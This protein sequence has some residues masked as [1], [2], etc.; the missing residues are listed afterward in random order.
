MSKDSPITACDCNVFFPRQNACMTHL[1]SFVNEQQEP[2]TRHRI[3]LPRVVIEESMAICLYRPSLGGLS[4]SLLSA[5]L[6]QGTWPT[7]DRIERETCGFCGDGIRQQSRTRCPGSLVAVTR[8]LDPW[9]FCKLCTGRT[10][11]W[12]S[13][14]SV[15]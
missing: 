14:P 5:V 4:C 15:G 9:L 7:S 12:K 11:E 2:S 1:D 6:G 10:F 8:M 13:T 3:C